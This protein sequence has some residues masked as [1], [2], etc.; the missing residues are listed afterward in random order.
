MPDR[1]RLLLVAL[2]ALAV[3]G[4]CRAQQ[5]NAQVFG[6]LALQCLAGA[7]GPRD[8][9]AV[10]ADPA[11][12][13]FL[14]PVLVGRWQAEGRRPY[15]PDSAGAALP[16]LRY[17]VDEARVAYRRAGRAVERRVVLALR[18][19]LSEPDGRL[20]ADQACT[21]SATDMLRPDEI[22]MVESAAFPETMGAAPAAGRFRRFVEPAVLTAASALS[23]YLFFTLRSG[24]GGS[25]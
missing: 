16:R 12:A 25:E 14:R 20:V 13:A 8:A 19:T 7:P 23:V 6:G 15:L 11:R 17:T 5:T 9:F 4:P 22:P 1:R 3:A 21:R 2:G 24:N 18:Y 10:E